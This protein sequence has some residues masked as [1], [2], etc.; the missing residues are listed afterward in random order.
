MWCLGQGVFKI[1]VLM[2]GI[3]VVHEGVQADTEKDELGPASFTVNVINR[4]VVF[5]HPLQYQEVSLAVSAFVDRGGVENQV[6]AFH[7]VGQNNND[8]WEICV[9]LEDL[10]S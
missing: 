5:Q 7:A 1:V 10:V 2:R 6:A 9:L 8:T 4:H 3:D